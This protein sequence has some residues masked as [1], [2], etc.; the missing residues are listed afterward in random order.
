M[1]LEGTDSKVHFIRHTPAMEQIRAAGQLKPNNFVSF[2]RVE[3]RLRMEDQGD[4]HAD[5][6]SDRLRQSARKLIHRGCAFR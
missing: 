4:S 2:E 5:L 3:G 6:S 1:I